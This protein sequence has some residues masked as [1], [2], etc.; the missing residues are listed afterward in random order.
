[1]ARRRR[2]SVFT[3]I[4]AIYA[5]DRVTETERRRAVQYE[6]RTMQ[7]LDILSDGQISAGLPMFQFDGE[8]CISARAKTRPSLKRRHRAAASLL[9]AA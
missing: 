9:D 1:M 8:E 4:A 2:R 5:G 3:I 7:A 6:R